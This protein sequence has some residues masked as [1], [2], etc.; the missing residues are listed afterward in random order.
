MAIGLII[1]DRIFSKNT[2]G[3]W[4]YQY[5]AR[6][7]NT[8]MGIILGDDYISYVNTESA[9]RAPVIVTLFGY[10]L[11]FFYDHTYAISDPGV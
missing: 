9:M 5:H 8:T 4:Y 6:L 10:S 11:R 7:K 1:S 3:W 2:V